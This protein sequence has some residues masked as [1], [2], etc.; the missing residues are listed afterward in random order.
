MLF[1]GHVMVET[2]APRAVSER[3]GLGEPVQLRTLRTLHTLH[4][5][6]CTLP[7]WQG[8]S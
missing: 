6:T 3:F 7:N 2:P 4:A 1:G 5:A 8:K